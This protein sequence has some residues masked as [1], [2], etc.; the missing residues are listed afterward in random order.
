VAIRTPGELQKVI[1]VV[2][3]NL[4]DGTIVETAGASTPL[5]MLTQGSPRPD[6]I[7]SH[8]NCSGCG[9]EFRLSCETYHG[10]GGSW[11]QTAHLS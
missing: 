5:S 3:D 10:G 9:E 1:R 8:F 2:K 4:D 11:S 6:F 7:Q